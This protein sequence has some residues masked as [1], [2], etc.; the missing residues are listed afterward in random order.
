MAAYQIMRRGCRNTFVHF[1]SY[2]HTSLEAQEKVRDLVRTLTTYQ[3]RSR[4]YLV[5]FAEVQ[6]QIVALT[7]SETRV[8][9]YRRYM[10][11]IAQRIAAREKAQA[12]LP[13]TASDRS[14]PR[15]WRTSERFPTRLESLC[16]AL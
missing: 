1:H 4:L 7:P 5:P 12:W 2:P 16:C 11:R 9:L 8:L 10:V 15:L 13:A 3:Y 14:L 6:R